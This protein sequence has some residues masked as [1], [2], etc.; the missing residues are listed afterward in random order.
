MP[1]QLHLRDLHLPQFHA[2]STDD[3]SHLAFGPRIRCRAVAPPHNLMFGH[4][5][6]KPLLG[7]SP[8]L[9]RRD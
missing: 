6:L 5:M 4:L 9:C 8:A 1:L 3:A 7:D 2:R